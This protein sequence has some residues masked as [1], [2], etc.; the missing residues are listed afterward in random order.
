VGNYPKNVQ[1]VS[2]FL[3]E[4]RSQQTLMDKWLH[5]AT[6][7]LFLSLIA[8]IGIALVFID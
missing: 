4:R 6:I 3:C 8:G 5:A 7:V 2:L 1:L